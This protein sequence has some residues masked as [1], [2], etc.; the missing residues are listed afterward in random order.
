MSQLAL[1]VAATLNVAEGM[2]K[3][4]LTN[5][6]SRVISCPSEDRDEMI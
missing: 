2:G 1:R 4:T 3:Q 6:D 5:S